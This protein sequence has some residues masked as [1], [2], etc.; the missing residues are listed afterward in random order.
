MPLLT[1]EDIFLSFSDKPL[2][3]NVAAVIHKGDK[4][5]LIGRNGAGKSTLLR[6]IAGIIKPD[7][8]EVIKK[9]DI[10]ISYL[11]QD[12]I[13]D[14]KQT[15]FSIVAQGLAAKG[16]L[17]SDYQL[18]LAN[19]SFEKTAILQDEIDNTNSWH[20]INAINKI[21]MQFDLDPNQHSSNLSGGMKKR[22]MLAKSLIAEPDVLL[23]DEPTNHLNIKSILYLEKLLIGLN[24]TLV[25]I[26]HDRSFVKNIANKI[27]DLDRAKIKV[28][29]CDYEKY[30][31]RKDEL[32]NAEQLAQK[33]FDK[34]LSQE[35]A[36]IRQGVKARRTRNEGRVK[37]LK[38]MRKEY[39]NNRAVSGN[40]KFHEIKPEYSSKIVFEVNNI[41]YEINNL[42]FIN[43]F[44]TLILRGDKI[45]IIGGNG[46]G[47]TTFIKV[48]LGDIQPT[49][50]DINRAQNI[51]LAYF[52][53]MR[54][55]ENLNITA[56]DY[57]SGGRDRI[58]IN[59]RSTHIIGYLR[60]FL[61]T[62]K[63]ARAPISYLSGGE[64]NRLI[65]A[66]IL[67]Q[68][69]NLLVLDEPSNDLDVE[70][71]ELL[72]DMLSNYKGTLIV[73]SHDRAFLNN[74]VSSTIVFETIGD[75]K[76]YAGGYDDYLIQRKATNTTKQD[77]NN[78]IKNT[79]KVDR[80]VTNINKRKIANVEKGIIKT[81]NKINSLQA[82]IS[83]DN[84]Y[85][86]TDAIV[87][88][89]LGQLQN[90]EDNLN[91]LYKQW[92]DLE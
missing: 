65:L 4:I 44:S 9:N 7:L 1:L 8:G 12:L 10:S 18:A 70:T 73:I 46:V 19:D 37:A 57:V 81:E 52:D 72:E 83:Q 47:K 82:K 85:K 69:A 16:K 51:K 87:K 5:A 62:S 58:D 22:L 2:L 33:R 11:E 43:N 91:L 6:L 42:K 27:F 74:I 34:K 3:D 40:A 55:I 59:G 13:I 25:F 15:L 84:F 39:L 80:N 31:I 61:F 24:T 76:Q 45:G 68:N 50:G 38:K 36:W 26:S 63:Q 14:D 77:K 21:I 32:L 41:S 90:L 53:Q 56:M 30:L 35:E 48:L 88:E 17:I 66:K 54:E 49:S 28:F 79:T 60:N 71:L 29:Y 67:S 75:I 78:Q 64:K 86:N 89:T 23:L 92:E 20:Y